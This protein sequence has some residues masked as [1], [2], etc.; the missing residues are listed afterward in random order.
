MN[1]PA[2][3]GLR[4]TLGPPQPLLSPV[5]ITNDCGLCDP[6][7]CC[8]RSWQVDLC[9]FPETNPKGLPHHG[10]N[11]WWSM[12]HDFAREDVVVS[13]DKDCSHTIMSIPTYPSEVD[14]HMCSTTPDGLLRYVKLGSHASDLEWWLERAKHWISV[15][16]EMMISLLPREFVDFSNVFLKMQPPLHFPPYIWCASAIKA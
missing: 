3:E 8:T 11:V 7:L 9:F 2:K 13:G 4:R 6:I 1:T 5:R 15:L 14:V 16:H 12:L 10:I